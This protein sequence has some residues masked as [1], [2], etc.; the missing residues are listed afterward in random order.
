MSRDAKSSD[1]FHPKT[2]ILFFFFQTSPLRI[3]YLGGGGNHVQK[4]S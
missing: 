4:S 3:E 1:G 2:L